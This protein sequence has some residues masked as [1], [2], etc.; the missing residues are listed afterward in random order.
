VIEVGMGGRWDS[1]NA[2]DSEVAV[3]TNVDLEHTEVLGKTRSEI[4]LN[5]VG[6]VKP[7]SVLVSG[8]SK[9][10]PVEQVVAEQAR[11]VGARIVHAVADVGTTIAGRNRHLAGR[12]LDSLGSMGVRAEGPTERRLVG[13]WLLT[14]EV[15]KAAK[16]PGRLEH[17]RLSVTTAGGGARISVILDGAHVASSLRA[18]ISDLKREGLAPTQCVAVVGLASDKDKQAFLSELRGNSDEVI[19][20]N[21]PTPSKAFSAGQ[22][23]KVARDLNLTV[24][25]EGD[26]ARALETALVAAAGK[27]G[28]VLV[29]GSLHLVGA[30]RRR[31]LLD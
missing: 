17:F 2:I 24:R 5:K 1:T 27:A 11:A 28:W 25:E 14:A 30:L 23:A 18:V 8:L 12:V 10:D 6:I 26:P 21:A 19:V 22:L 29:T 16:L 13:D 7:G 9:D 4:A 15:Q 3:I 31:C 20:T